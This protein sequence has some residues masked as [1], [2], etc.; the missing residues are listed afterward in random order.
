MLNNFIVLFCPSLLFFTLKKYLIYM[1]NTKIT[2]SLS[3]FSVM[4]LIF[5]ISCT[6]TPS[7]TTKETGSPTIG[8]WNNSL[9]VATHYGLISGKTD[10]KNTYA[11]LGIPYAAPPVGDLRWKAPQDP[12][13][14]HGVRSATKF[15]P[16]A[17]QAAALLGWTQGS[18]DSLYLNV[19][20]PATEQSNLPVYVWIHGGGNSSG[21]ADASP[22]YQ[23]F[24]LASN[25]NTVFV[26]INYRLGLFGWFNH[27]ALKTGTDADTDSGNFGTLDI[28][29]ALRWVHENISSFGGNPDMVTVG[30]ESAGAFN[31]LTL[32]MAPSARG[33]FQ[34]A[35]VESGYRT[36]T[37]PERAEAFANDIIKRLLVKEH[38]AEN[39]TEAEKLLISMPEKELAVWLKSLSS[40][41]LMSVIKAGNSGMLPFPYPVFDGHVLPA[42]GFAALEDRSK[43]SVVPLIIGTNKEE[44]KIFQWLGGQKSSDPLYQPLAELTSAR[45]KADGAD[46]IADALTSAVP[47][48]PVYVYRFDWGAPDSTGKSVMPGKLGALFGAFHSL[49]IPFFLGSDTVLGKSVPI[50]FFTKENEAGRVALQLQMGQYLANLIHTGNPNQPGSLAQN[51]NVNNL[52]AWERWNA[53]D[54]SPGFMIFDASLSQVQTRLEYGRTTRELVRQRLET[55]FQ[56]PLKTRLLAAYSKE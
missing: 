21:S 15:G 17:V 19:W 6:T 53:T 7:G 52:P 29:K 39:E 2:W 3:I 48:Y 12:A 45:W 42:E 56:E 37:T 26:S 8:S 36:N 28:I 4:G 24:N 22:S 38:K 10:Q 55:E 31:I 47:E 49:E 30:G 23:G 33:L 43:I 40:K 46:S 20:R 50:K 44:T 14:W 13:P 35:V 54:Q 34:R 32:L 9:T 18:E 11:W 27:P 1:S 16:K 5:A 51:S 41:K 25:A